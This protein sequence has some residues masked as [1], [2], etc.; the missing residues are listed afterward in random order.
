MK[1]IIIIVLVGIFTL[2]LS[3]IL[4]VALKKFLGIKS[5]DIAY[6][7]FYI[8]V[9]L[10]AYWNNPHDF[11]SIAIIVVL[12]SLGLNLLATLLDVVLNKKKFFPLFWKNI[13]R[14][15]CWLLMTI[16]PAMI[17]LFLVS[18]FVK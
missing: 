14:S 15:A 6:A 3:G 17:I 16:V 10:G 11:S 1:D 12:V 5:G 8:A 2:V 9:V 4:Q 7:T 13:F 18:V